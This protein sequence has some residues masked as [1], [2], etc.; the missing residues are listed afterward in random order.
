MRINTIN[1]V[2]EVPEPPSGEIF[3]STGDRKLRLLG[4]F[5]PV[6]DDKEWFLDT[7]GIGFYNPVDKTRSYWIL[8]PVP[9]PK[10]LEEQRRER[11]DELILTALHAIHRGHPLGCYSC[12]K[13]AD[14]VEKLY[15]ELPVEEK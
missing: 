8:V 3:S 12:Q 7:D 15:H 6:K 9:A 14:Q 13:F 1:G 4:E 2:I 5:R 10:S 11:L